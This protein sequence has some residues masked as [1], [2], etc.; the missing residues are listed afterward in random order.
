VKPSGFHAPDH[1]E[2]VDMVLGVE[3]K[4]AIGRVSGSMSPISS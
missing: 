3:P 4:T 2:A 1:R